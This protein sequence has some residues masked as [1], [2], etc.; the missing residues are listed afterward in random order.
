MITGTGSGRVVTLEIGCVTHV[1]CLGKGITL[2][3][4]GMWP[5][6]QHM[7]GRSQKRLWT[8]EPKNM[9]GRGHLGD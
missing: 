3:T 5:W 9:L 2:E 4:V 8:C 1:Q 6:V 7:R